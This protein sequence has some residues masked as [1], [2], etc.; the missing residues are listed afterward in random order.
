MLFVRH[1]AGKQ[2]FQRRLSCF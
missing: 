1:E 2:L